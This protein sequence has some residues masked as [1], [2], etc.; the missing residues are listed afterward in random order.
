VLIETLSDL[1]EGGNQ[2]PTLVE[3]AEAV[4]EKQPNFAMDLFVS[5]RSEDRERALS[6]SDDGVINKSALSHGEVYSTHTTFQYKAMLFHVG[7]LTERGTGTKSKLDPT[8]DIW[9]LETH[10]Q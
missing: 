1:A 9:A 7:L 6:D 2:K 3:V 8:S 5:T 10:T 4:A